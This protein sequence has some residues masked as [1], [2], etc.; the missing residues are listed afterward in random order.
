MTDTTVSSQLEILRRIAER[1]LDTS[2]RAA[3]DVMVSPPGVDL[4]QHM[5]DE[6]ARTKLYHDQQGGE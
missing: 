5:I 1:G 6:V 2:Q 4:W 3:F